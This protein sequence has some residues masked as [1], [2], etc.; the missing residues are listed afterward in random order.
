MYAPGKNSNITNLCKLVNKG[1]QTPL[2]IYYGLNC[3][4]FL[5][6]S[7]V[8]VPNPVPQNVTMFR[9]TVFEEVIQLEWGHRGGPQSTITS[10]FIRRGNLETNTQK[11]TMWRHRESMAI[12]M[13]RTETS[14]E[15]NSSSDLQPPE[16]WEN[17]FP[18]FEPPSLWHFVN[19]SS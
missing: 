3:V 17:K 8:E 1:P 12:C 16:V 7:C 4:F 11:E 10:V 18:L 19:G 2:P 6:N 15:T 5:P 13:S 14:E 9:D